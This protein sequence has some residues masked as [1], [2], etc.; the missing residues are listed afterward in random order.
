MREKEKEELRKQIRK[1]E[2]YLM[3]KRNI[4]VLFEQN[5]GNFYCDDVITINSRQNLRYQLH[6]LLHEAGHA[7]I[8]SNKRGFLEKY[9]G[10][11]KRKSSKSYRLDTLKEEIEA[12]SRGYNLATRLEIDL[13]EDWWKRHSEE[14]LYDYVKWVAN[15]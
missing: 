10:L 9:P 7:L 12:W 2:N 8:R 15:V 1:V 14:C 3:D 11:S 4:F 13:D 5:V 6:T